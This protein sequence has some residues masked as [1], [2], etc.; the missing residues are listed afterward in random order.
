MDFSTGFNKLTDQKRIVNKICTRFLYM[1][2]Y[3]LKMP[4]GCTR[5][6]T[7][8]ALQ[9]CKTECEKCGKEFNEARQTLPKR[10]GRD[11]AS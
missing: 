6:S 1:G 2:L 3:H 9:H 8:K 4:C 7:E 11:R 5:P 10:R